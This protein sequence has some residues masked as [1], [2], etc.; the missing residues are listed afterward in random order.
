MRPT[1]GMQSLR[2]GRTCWGPTVSQTVGGLWDPLA[3]AEERS[4]ES[5]RASGTQ[6]YTG[7]NDLVAKEMTNPLVSKASEALSGDQAT[8]Q[9]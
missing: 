9:Q 7:C 2:E 3:V 5:R 4:T 8:A 1:A 6:Q